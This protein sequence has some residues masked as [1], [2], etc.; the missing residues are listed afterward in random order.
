MSIPFKLLRSVNKMFVF[1]NVAAVATRKDR[2]V[3]NS[4][5]SL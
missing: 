4:D 5:Y 2:F 1:S 3:S